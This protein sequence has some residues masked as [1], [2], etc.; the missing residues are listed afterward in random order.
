[1]GKRTTRDK[2]TGKFTRVLEIW[3]GTKWDEGWYDNRDRFRVYRP[4]YPR[5]FTGGYALRAWVVWW[6]HY[7]IPHLKGTNLH[8]KNGMKDDDRLEN[9]EIIDHGEHSRLHLSIGDIELVCKNCEQIF[10]IAKRKYNA[11]IKEGNPIKFCSQKCY[12]SFPK[13]DA[14]VKKLSMS[15][16]KAYAEGRKKTPAGTKHTKKTKDKMAVSQRQRRERERKLNL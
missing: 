15:L 7:G 16:K 6:L 4:D 14:V 5:A 9:L 12:H 8:H 11:R 10:I 3:D 13:S 1:M 2:K